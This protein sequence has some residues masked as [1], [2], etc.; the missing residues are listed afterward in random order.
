MDE[1][2]AKDWAVPSC[3]SQLISSPDFAFVSREKSGARLV[4]SVS[5]NV[6]QV[7][8]TFESVGEILE[9]DNSNESY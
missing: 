9:C 4:L 5:L 2:H 8:L 6:V 3:G 1:I 7:V